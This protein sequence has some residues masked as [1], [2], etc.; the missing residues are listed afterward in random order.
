MTLAEVEK[1]SVRELRHDFRAYYG[2]RYDDVEADEA[3]DLIA[4][5]PDGSLYVSK[6]NPSRSWTPQRE[7]VACLQDTLLEIACA[8]AGI[9]DE[10][11]RV[12]RPRDVVARRSA[13]RKAAAVRERIASTSWTGQEGGR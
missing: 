3:L 13:R 7:A 1:G 10:P 11:P 4:T 5:L 8:Q 9:K 6:R 12:T 2:C